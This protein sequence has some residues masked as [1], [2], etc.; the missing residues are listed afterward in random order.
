[1]NTGLGPNLLKDLKEA[2]LGQQLDTEVVNYG[3]ILSCCLWRCLNLINYS[4]TLKFLSH[5]AFP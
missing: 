5:P 1:M 4:V 3:S 2:R